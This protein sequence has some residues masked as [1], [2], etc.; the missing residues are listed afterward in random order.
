MTEPDHHEYRKTRIALAC[1][2][3]VIMGI[4]LGIYIYDRKQPRNNLD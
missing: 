3:T 1:I 4:A 2:Q